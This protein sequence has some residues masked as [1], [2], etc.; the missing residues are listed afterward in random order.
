MVVPCAGKGTAIK[1]TFN[2][3]SSDSRSSS[4][5]YTKICLMKNLIK[6]FQK[7]K[8]YLYYFQIK[9][10]SMEHFSLVC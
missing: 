9:F 6:V 2:K 4:S 1:G 3:D 5:C 8:F 10:L 7:K